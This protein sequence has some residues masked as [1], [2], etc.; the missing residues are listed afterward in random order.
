[1]FALKE[2]ALEVHFLYILPI[3]TSNKSVYV[4][5]IEIEIIINQKIVLIN[6]IVKLKELD[7]L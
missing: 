7:S 3:D 4:K 1:M 2:T 6:L 5:L